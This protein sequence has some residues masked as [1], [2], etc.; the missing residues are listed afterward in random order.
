MEIYN[1]ETSNSL[2]NTT[3][4]VFIDDLSLLKLIGGIVIAGILLIILN[5]AI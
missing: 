1:T 2:L 5:K 4:T 3:V